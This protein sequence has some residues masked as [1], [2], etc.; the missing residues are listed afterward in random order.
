MTSC[1]LWAGVM[2]GTAG[3]VLA[4]SVDAKLLTML[5]NNGSITQA[6]Y[7]ELSADL[8]KQQKAAVSTESVSKADF[9]ALQQKVAWAARTVVSGD[10][11]VRNENISIQHR[12]PERAQDRQRYRARVAVVSQITEEVEAGVRV[13]S[14]NLNDPRSTNQDMNDYFI[15]KQ[16]W[17]DRAYVSYHPTEVPG[18][19]VIGGKMAQPWVNEDEMIWDS[20]INPEGVASQYSHA[21]GPVKLFGSTG[22]FTLK[23]NVNGEG[24]EFT[25]DLRMISAQ[26]GSKFAVAEG[27]D[28]TLGGSLYHFH[29][30]GDAPTVPPALIGL[31]AVGNTTTQFQLWEGFGQL[32]I[33]DFALPLAFYGQY[34]KNVNANGP[35]SDEDKGWLLGVKSKIWNIGLNYNYRNVQRNAVVGAFT[36]SD[37]AAGYTGSRGSKIQVSY[38]IA[39]NFVFQTTYMHAQSNAASTQA[40]S[41][42][43]TWLIDFAASF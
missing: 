11:R 37:F 23:D 33:S 38:P 17:L 27:Y 39:K 25:N 30:D 18:L 16:L 42:V 15:K 43:D 6:Q 14:G 41:D 7:A 22:A 26:L 29:L 8:A 28:V 10:V 40:G 4:E 31:S 2:L 13:A 34:V 5:R 32:D 21:L 12:D 20:D 36:D 3:P 19:N 24:R 1:V 35:Q 9:D